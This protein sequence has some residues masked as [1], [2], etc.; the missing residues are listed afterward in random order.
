MVIKPKSRRSGFTLVEIMI[1]VAIIAMLAAIAVPS[2]LRARKRSQAT[3]SLETL[4]MLDG[5][6][7]QY[8][9]ETGHND[10]N[11]IGPSD[12]AGYVKS[13]TVLYN[14]L[15]NNQNATDALGTPFEIANSGPDAQLVIAKSTQDALSDVIANPQEFWGAYYNPN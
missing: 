9:I 8:K 12:I 6:V 4:R 5:A 3:V 13:G 10:S 2:F 1:V 11:G 7:D 14:Q 15:I